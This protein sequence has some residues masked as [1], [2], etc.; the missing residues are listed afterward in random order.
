MRPY[1]AARP[2]PTPRRYRLWGP[3]LALLWIGAPPVQASDAS[4]AVAVRPTVVFS[5]GEVRATVRTPRDARNRELRVLIEAADFYASSDVQLDGDE[6]PATHQFSWKALPGGDYRVE[7]ILLREDGEERRVVR[8]FAVLG[9]EQ[10]RG[11]PGRRTAPPQP[12]TG[13]C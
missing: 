7:A 2:R 4:V 10:S 3:S 13:G 8:C 1:M 12:D 11:E 6:A 9:E 5:G